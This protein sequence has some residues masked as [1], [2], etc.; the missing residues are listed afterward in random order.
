MMNNKEKIAPILTQNHA[1][2]VKFLAMSD[3]VIRKNICQ[4]I[5]GKPKDGMAMRLSVVTKVICGALGKW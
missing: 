5:L 2:R 3:K 1:K 4:L